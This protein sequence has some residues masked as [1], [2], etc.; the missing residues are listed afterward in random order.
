M[1]IAFY[2]PL[3]SPDHPNPSGDRHMARLLMR[4]L[5]GGGHEVTLASRFRSREGRGDAAT[6]AHIERV[7]RHI[8]KTL[9]QRWQGNDQGRPDLW[10]T[11]HLYHKAPDWLGPAVS[12]ALGIPYVIVEASHAAKQAD[13]PWAG[14]YHAA[15]S[16]LNQADA[17]ISLNRNDM[18]G[19]EQVVTPVSRVHYLAPFVDC[20]G[21]QSLDRQ[22]TRTQLALAQGLATDVPWLLVVAMMRPGDKTASYGLLAKSLR[23]VQDQPWR[24]VVIGDGRARASVLSALLTLEHSRLRFLGQ[25][26][27]DAVAAWTCASD[28]LVWPAVNE[29]YGMALLEAQEAG[30]PV[31]AGAG[32][33]V[34]DVVAD[35]ETGLLTPVGDIDAFAD[36]TRQLLANPG[37][38]LAMSTRSRQRVHAGHCLTH[39]T[40][41]LQQILAPLI[42]G[43]AP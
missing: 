22:A 40:N 31:V 30:L 1:R 18:A 7:G 14:G 11:Y 3:K 37:E 26:D 28:L 32:G 24:L 6:Q 9:V 21:A 19:L 35:G 42:R 13:G 8:A 25:L 29:A 43:R 27:R 10:L 33:G 36:A 5:E 41:A 15:I 16:A 20:E 38:R 4:A 12:A 17:V 2:A 23:K 34:P 39:A